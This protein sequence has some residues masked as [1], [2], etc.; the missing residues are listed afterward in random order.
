[1]KKN[2]IL[3]IFLI[4]CS[5]GLGYLNLFLLI[6]VLFILVGVYS[7][8]KFPKLNILLFIVF[9]SS[10]GMISTTY[11][12]FGFLH[13]SRIINLFAIVT[14]LHH[15]PI[16]KDKPDVFRKV[17]LY[18]IWFVFVT[19]MIIQFKV[20]EYNFTRS[21]IEFDSVVKRFIKYA[22]L[23][24]SLS[25]LINRFHVKSI[26]EIVVLGLVISIIFL[27]SSVLLA[28]FLSSIGFDCKISTSGEDFLTVPR[29]SGFFMND[30]DENTVAGII[31]LI[32]GLLV[33]LSKKYYK[34]IPINTVFLFAM[35]GIL[36]TI[37]R[38]GSIALIGIFVLFVLMESKTSGSNYKLFF[39][40]SSIVVFLL[41][42]G[43]LEN[44]INR[45][46]VIEQTMVD[47]ND[48]R[49]GGWIFYL[50]YIFSDISIVLWGATENLYE[51]TRNGHYFRVAHNFYI[52][53][54]YYSGV[55]SLITI[56][57]ILFLYVKSYIKKVKKPYM[58]L[59]TL[60]PFIMITNTTSDVG[61]FFSFILSIA[62]TSEFYNQQ[63]TIF[64]K[65][66]V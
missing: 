26:K 20:Y 49:Y 50:N 39:V 33:S 21:S 40:V 52:S 59:Y 66:N 44:I 32:T 48:S 60:F 4:T 31:S 61:I 30:G 43:Y 29:K 22:L 27:S 7:Y 24:I 58:I 36:G 38:A 41:F 14:L 10:N 15:F 35:L 65:A 56:F 37:S 46:S 57:G 62:F 47:E 13:V 45:F 18:L 1:M 3:F 11:N 64:E 42:G 63:Q 28:D 9:L 25:M 51:G 17:S 5:I 34:I 8:L 23:A 53:N 55:F 54:L 16:G 2:I 19:I 12:L 6:N